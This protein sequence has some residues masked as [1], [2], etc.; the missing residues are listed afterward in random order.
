M[1][2]PD[3]LRTL[4]I[5]VYGKADHWVCDPML[6]VSLAAGAGKLPAV[7]ISEGYKY[8]GITMNAREGDLSAEELLTHGLNRT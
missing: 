5:A 2:N 3:K 4:T 8:I 1:S 6:F 7:S